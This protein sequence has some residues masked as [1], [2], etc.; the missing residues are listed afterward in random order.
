MNDLKLQEAILR[1]GPRLA[2]GMLHKFSIHAAKGPWDAVSIGELVHGL[3]EEVAELKAA[4]VGGRYPEILDECADVANY[5][6]MIADHEANTRPPEPER[7]RIPVEKMDDADFGAH[8]GALLRCAYIAASGVR[9]LLELDHRD[10]HD[11][12]GPQLGG[13]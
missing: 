6:L 2:L 10:G 12:G 4:L 8:M 1:A 11:F 7:L 5:C 13:K 9:C 3:D